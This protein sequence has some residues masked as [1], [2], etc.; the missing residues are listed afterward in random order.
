VLQ[1]VQI[2]FDGAEEMQDGL[3]DAQGGP[4]SGEIA[5]LPIR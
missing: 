3:V 5:A 1:V 4:A 2:L